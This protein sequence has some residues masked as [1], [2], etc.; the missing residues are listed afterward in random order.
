MRVHRHS[1]L[2]LGLVLALS[3][4]A[5]AQSNKSANEAVINLDTH[6]VSLTVT[7]TDKRGRHLG[8][9]EQG[10]FS[11][12]EDQV[13]QELSFF[14]QADAPASI[15]IVFDLSGSMREDKI[16][17]ARA[18]LE[19]FLA[20]CHPDDEYTLIGFNQ[21][22]WIAQERTRDSQQLLRQF[23]GAK[24]DGNTALYDALA[25]GLAQLAHGA[26]A[27]RVLL[28]ISDGEDNHSRT[29]FRQIKRQAQESS[30]LIYAIGI[31]DWMVRQHTGEIVLEELAAETGGKA[32]FPRN[33]EAMS[34]AF[35]AIALELRQQYSLGY[36]PSSFVPDN[37][38]RKL[39]VKVTP[40]ADTSGIV[41]R[42]RVGYYA[43][44][45]HGTGE[46]AETAR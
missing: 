15:T 13:A 9:L 25:L 14:N 32:F 28:V 36:T 23:S 7:V 27:R 46:V 40:P 31:S 5:H 21:Q 12:Y 11:V 18:A 38:W 34:E 17:R 3:L 10:A 20:N 30:A 33:T 41:V 42:A 19:R 24:P 16:T 26:H 44:P 8:G 2:G 45:K 39:K 37:K 6:V 22:A 35:E 4:V 1:W 29:T 43:N